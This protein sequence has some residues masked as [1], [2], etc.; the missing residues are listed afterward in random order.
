MIHRRDINEDPSFFAH[1]FLFGLQDWIV[2]AKNLAVGEG[3]AELERFSLGIPPIREI[4]INLVIGSDGELAIASCAGIL[5]MGFRRGC[6]TAEQNEESEHSEP[7]RWNLRRND[8]TT[9]SA[10]RSCVSLRYIVG[11]RIVA[12]QGTENRW[13]WHGCC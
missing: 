6:G 11:I 2:S 12:H 3:H 7:P 10:T 13:F 5:F 1:R 8:M 9:A 4:R